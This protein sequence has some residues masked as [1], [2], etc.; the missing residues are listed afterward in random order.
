MDKEMED[1]VAGEK[2]KVKESTRI[3]AEKRCA[4]N[5]ARM[6]REAN[7]DYGQPVMIVSKSTPET[8]ANFEKWFKGGE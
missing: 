1:F 2:L 4:E 3:F 5:R 7:G 6:K 8:K